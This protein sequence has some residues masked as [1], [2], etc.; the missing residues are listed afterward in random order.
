QPVVVEF[1]H[2]EHAMPKHVFY[3]AL[4]LST[5]KDAPITWTASIY[6]RNLFPDMPY[7]ERFVKYDKLYVGY[8]LTKDTLHSTGFSQVYAG[9]FVNLY[10]NSL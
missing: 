3:H 5:T 1:I 9:I 6:S 7:E 10:K 2:Y 4:P 8:I